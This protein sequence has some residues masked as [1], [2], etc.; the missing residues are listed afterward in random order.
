MPLMNFIESRSI[1]FDGS[2]GERSEYR[3]VFEDFRKLV[4]FM[5][6]SFREDVEISRQQLERACQDL[7]S[8]IPA[9]QN[10]ASAAEGS[11]STV[12]AAALEQIRATEDYPLF[13]QMMARINV[14]LQ[15]QT[16]KMLRLQWGLS[17]ELASLGQQVSEYEKKVLEEV[18]K[19]SLQEHY[20]EEREYETEAMD[21]KKALT[22]SE[23][24]KHHQEEQN[25]QEKELIESVL[26]LSIEKDNESTLDKNDELN[27][28]SNGPNTSAQGDNETP[29]SETNLIKEISREEM[30]Q[31]QLYLRQQRDKLMAMK[32]SQREE[33]LDN[34]Q[35]SLKQKR[36]KSSRAARD[37]VRGALDTKTLEMRRQ[38]AETLRR[39]VVEK[40]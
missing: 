9:S 38:M 22:A 29:S 5:L 32:R 30:I 31:R 33:M 14:E 6:T 23:E 39:E 3:E 28:D 13:C 15:L 16:I 24:D 4:A 8:S 27:L 18:M 7:T 10:T 37:L 34:D 17:G 25:R 26:H 19:K 35:R 2:S 36:P 12:V 40:S 11:T 1:I 20:E 21:L